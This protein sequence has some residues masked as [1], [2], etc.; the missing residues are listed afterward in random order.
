MK[1]LNEFFKRVIIAVVLFVIGHFSNA[2]LAPTNYNAEYV[3]TAKEIKKKYQRNAYKLN[4]AKSGHMGLR[5][6]RNY[7]DDSY[8]YLLL[9]GIHYT[10]NALDKLVLRGLDARSLQQY[11]TQKNKS[12]KASTQKK[13][14]R[15]KTF[16]RF[17]M[18]RLM[19]VKILRHVAR[20]DELGLRHNEHAQFM[21]LLRSY[22]FKKAFTDREMIKAWGAQLANQV[23]WLYNLGIADYRPDFIEAVQNTYPQ[24]KDAFLSKAQFGNKIYT[25]THIIIAASSYY[26][27][28]VNYEEHQST[29]DYLRT[30]TDLILERAKEDIVIEVGLSLLLVDETYPEITR[31]KS[32]I[33]S[34]VD[35][36]KDMILSVNGN[37]KIAQG[38]HRNII[39]VLLLDWK[40]CSPVPNSKSMEMIQ[41]LLPTSLSLI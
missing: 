36:K 10:S 29:I 7:K 35:L 13:K 4:P 37:S 21:D 12:Y 3:K 1:Y 24:E 31:I 15:K 8:K 41:S 30:N 6:W 39:A 17:P 20:L 2:Q 14:R 5:L 11:V 9:E 34:K 22:D 16:E 26:S 28:E 19:G 23:Y 25:L 38:E 18:Y 32:F 40:G 33:H 27:Q